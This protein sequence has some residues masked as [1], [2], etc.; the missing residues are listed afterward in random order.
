MTQAPSF[1]LDRETFLRGVGKLPSLPAV[2]VEVMESLNAEQPVLKQ[3]ARK[4]SRDQ[5][6]VAKMLRIANSSFYGLRG[7]VGSIDDAIQVLGLRGIRSLTVTAAVSGV[8]STVPCPDFD[9]PR[10]WRHSI[11]TA[12]CARELARQRGFNDGY[13]FVAGLLHDV[14]HL[15][16]ASCF[17]AHLA[18]IRRTAGE[19]G[20]SWLLTE[21]RVLGVD[22]AALG[23]MLTTHWHFPQIISEAIALHHTGGASMD[24][25]GGVLCLSN[26]L[27][28][29]LDL[30][31]PATGQIPQVDAQTR[32]LL[33]MS[34][35]AWNA[36]VSML[37]TQ[38][39]EACAQLISV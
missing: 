35:E 27:V 13:A 29:A 18:A 10:F 6:L 32:A 25:L 39:A 22:H 17:P 9:L 16:L 3:L 11:A 36:L 2:L 4:L 19:T 26:A 24:T 23:R 21:E 5:A 34:D 15:V 12:L 30:D 33:G 8:F 14:G 1:L 28:H 7:Q 37:Q 20:Q 31:N 38:T